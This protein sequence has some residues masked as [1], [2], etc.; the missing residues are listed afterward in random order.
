MKP[1]PILACIALCLPASA[2]LP[3]TREQAAANMLHQQ[4]IRAVDHI[5]N[6]YDFDKRGLTERQAVIET[7]AKMRESIASLE[8]GLRFADE[9]TGAVVAQPVPP[10]APPV[11]VIRSP[12]INGDGVVDGADIGLVLGAWGQRGDGQ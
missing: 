9:L 7:I 4:L 3:A 12:D 5:P 11:T 8:A 1:T 10:P 2:Q 6:W